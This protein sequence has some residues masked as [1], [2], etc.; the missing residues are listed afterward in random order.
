MA[1]GNHRG[2]LVPP[3][4]GENAFASPRLSGCWRKPAVPGYC[5]DAGLRPGSATGLVP[6]DIP[7][8]SGPASMQSGRLA[9]A[10]LSVDLLLSEDWRFERTG[11]A[12]R[13]LESRA[14]GHR[15]RKSPSAPSG[16]EEHF[17][18][19]AVGALDEAW[20]RAW[21]ASWSDAFRGKVQ[22]SHD[23][24][25]QRGRT[26]HGLGSRADRFNLEE[27]LGPARSAFENWAAIRLWSVSRCGKPRLDEFLRDV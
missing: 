22:P 3:L 13:R 11:A 21:W 12:V 23:R 4:Q 10:A 8:A 26:R 25:R 19:P 27:I 20:H 9:D 16:V 17:R 1:M 6:S 2:N 18:R 15:A 5:A 7:S 24:A 14:P